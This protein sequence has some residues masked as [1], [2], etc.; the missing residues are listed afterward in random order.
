MT[1]GERARAL[2][3]RLVTS[4]RGAHKSAHEFSAH[5]FD[6][7]IMKRPYRAA[8]LHGS[9]SFL[10]LTKKGTSNEFASGKNKLNTAQYISTYQK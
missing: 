1:S 5:T 7:L 10:L 4:H 6:R 9:V 3:H 2:N 8:E